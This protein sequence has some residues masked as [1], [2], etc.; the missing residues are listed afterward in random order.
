MH[1]GPFYTS[2]TKSHS[3]SPPPCVCVSLMFSITPFPSPTS[4][5]H[6]C[7]CE[8]ERDTHYY[9]ASLIN[10]VERSSFITLSCHMH[11]RTSATVYSAVGTAQGMSTHQGQTPEKAF[12]SSDLSLTSAQ[13]TVKNIVIASLENPVRTNYEKIQLRAVNYKGESF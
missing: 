6:V 10:G 4:S 9:M 2:P 5:L 11:I 13:T 7:V 8:Q 12:N 1:N 3:S